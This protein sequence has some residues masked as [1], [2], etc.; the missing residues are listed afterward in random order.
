MVGQGEGSMVGG[1]GKMS[2]VGQEKVRRLTLLSATTILCLIYSEDRSG[3]KIICNSLINSASSA[4]DSV[5][6]LKSCQLERFKY[7]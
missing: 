5:G 4:Y 7:K 2:V 3:K 1:Q 6:L